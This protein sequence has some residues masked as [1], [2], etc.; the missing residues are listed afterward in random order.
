MRKNSFSIRIPGYPCRNSYP[1]E[2][3]SDPQI[4]VVVSVLFFSVNLLYTFVREDLQLSPV[5]TTMSN[6]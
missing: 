6:L 2:A 1:K 3:A 4:L 5:G